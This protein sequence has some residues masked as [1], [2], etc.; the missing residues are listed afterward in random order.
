MNRI[1]AVLFLLSVAF[2]SSA[3]N[4]SGSRKYD[5]VHSSEYSAYLMGG[6]NVVTGTFVGE[7]VTYTRHLSDRWS[8]SV[9]EQVQFLKQLYSFDVMGTYRLPVGKSD[10]FFD[11]RFLFNRYNRWRVNEPIL[12]LTAFWQTRFVDLRIGGSY[13]H[14]RMV[15][16][17]T[18]RTGAGY[19]EPVAVTVGFGINL[20]PRTNPWNLGLFIRNYDHFY[21][22]NWNINWGLRFYSTLREQMKLFGEFN[23]R[24]AGSL[25]QLATRYETSLKLGLRYVL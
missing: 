2:L 19:T 23:I 16:V 20:M 6:Y 15:G 12:H 21:Y 7:A 18:R 10:I 11:G 9:G 4:F 8:A 5:G 22:E 1:P 24:P 3:Q 17:D 13:I 25:S 14:Y